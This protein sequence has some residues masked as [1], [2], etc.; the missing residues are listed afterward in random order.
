[1]SRSAALS[2]GVFVA[3]LALL[4]ATRGQQG[5]VGLREFAL[6]HVEAAEIVEINLSGP[7]EA[8]LQRG[9]TGWSVADPAN[10]ERSFPA[11]PTLVE[12]LLEDIAALEIAGFVTGRAESQA[13]LAI[14]E[15]QG[16]RLQ[17]DA[18]LES[19]DLIL[20]RTAKGGGDLVRR[21]GDDAVFETRAPL[22]A[23]ARH[24][25]S[26]WRRR[27]ITQLVPDAVGSI[28]IARPGE[29]ELLL[30]RESGESG[31]GS[32]WSLAEGP[33]LP[34]GFELDSPVV[35]RA[36]SG[37]AS[38]RAEAFVDEDPGE[39]TT[40]LGDPIL[41]E[42]SSQSGESLAVLWLGSPDAA[43]DVYLRS[44]EDPQLYLVSKARATQIAP[45]FERLRDLSL[46][47]GGL[48]EAVKLEIAQPGSRMELL[49]RDGVWE[50]A[51]GEAPAGFELDSNRVAGRLSA[52]G[53]TQ[54]TRLL[55]D[56]E[57]QAADFSNPLRIELTNQD[58]QTRV[59]EFGSPLEANEGGE[60]LAARTSDGL[61][62][63]ARVMERAR[64]EDPWK[65]FERVAPS[66][67]GAGGVPTL[68]S[69][70]P[71]LRRQ[72]EEQRRQQGAR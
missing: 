69:L 4:L 5:G 22:A 71:E 27:Q 34:A 56:S 41:V 21:A 70:P 6:P 30:V 62:V 55:A 40:G 13:D 8:K 54:G 12:R 45:P 19:L 42:V 68:E 2:L 20:G 18:G 72:I 7:V 51:G 50:L 49:K 53:R 67:P 58:G 15:A 11:E 32:V 10:P 44:G 48:D 63:A 38:L 14:D 47:R 46:L 25:L 1:M 35:R 26:G 66:P 43:G 36:A 31:A 16:L 64:Y 9:D 59:V 17:V 61:L 60:Q 39:A 33:V 28:R 3:L 29:S 37:L 65:L 57:A 23:A 52:L 24:D